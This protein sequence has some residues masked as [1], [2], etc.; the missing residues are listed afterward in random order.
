MCYA[1]WSKALSRI[2][3]TGQASVDL[4]FLWALARDFKVAADALLE[5]DEFS[6]LSGMFATRPR[7]AAT[8]LFYALSKLEDS[9]MRTLSNDLTDSVPGAQIVAYIYDGFIAIPPPHVGADDV[10]VAM[11]SF[12]DVHKLTWSMTRI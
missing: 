1:L 6:Y 7:P 8:R 4:P 5:S 9:M 11:E 3:F 10:E 2:L 12:T